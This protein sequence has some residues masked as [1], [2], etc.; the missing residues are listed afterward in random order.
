MDEAR[1]KVARV[2]NFIVAGGLDGLDQRVCKESEWVMVDLPGQ[3]DAVSLV[4]AERA[5]EG[6]RTGDCKESLKRESAAPGCLTAIESGRYGREMVLERR[7]AWMH[8]A[9]GCGQWSV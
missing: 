8:Q 5:K 7:R 6:G 9:A 1:E 3:G 4:A 2:E